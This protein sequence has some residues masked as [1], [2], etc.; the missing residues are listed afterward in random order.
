MVLWRAAHQPGSPTFQ[1]TEG[2]AQDSLDVWGAG[3][4][5]GGPR[6]W[7]AEGK[8]RDT[9]MA[10]FSKLESCSGLCFC[11]IGFAVWLTTVTV[12]SDALKHQPAGFVPALSPSQQRLPEPM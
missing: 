5:R 6:A 7:I 11:S 1:D 12:G 4:S 3:F 2:K 8:G 10:H 9:A